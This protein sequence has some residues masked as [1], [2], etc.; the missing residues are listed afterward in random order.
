MC[1]FR[2]LLYKIAF[3]NVPDGRIM[4]RLRCSGIFKAIFNNFEISSNGVKIA[5]Y[6][7]KISSNELKIFSTK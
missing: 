1:Y 4:D 7:L 5:S 2:K 6:E 3:K